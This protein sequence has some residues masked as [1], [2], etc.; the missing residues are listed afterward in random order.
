[1]IQLGKDQVPQK[2]KFAVIVAYYKDKTYKSIPLE[3]I[4]NSDNLKLVLTLSDI[5]TSQYTM[6][7]LPTSMTSFI[8]ISKEQLNETIFEVFIHDENPDIATDPKVV[9]KTKTKAQAI[10]S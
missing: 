9:K 3:L 7:K 5:G 10:N 2:N 6:M 8:I 1:M 4:D